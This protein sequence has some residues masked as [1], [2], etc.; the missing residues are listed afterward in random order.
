MIIQGEAGDVFDSVI[1]CLFT[2][3]D[4]TDKEVR[5]VVRPSST[6]GLRKSSYVM[7]DK[8]ITVERN[9]LLGFV[10]RLED[11]QMHEIS[12][13]LARLLVITKEDVE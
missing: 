7:T 2:T 11:T 6:N 4:S 9:E 10:G 5:V 12:R 3:F 8:I 1:L 13:Q